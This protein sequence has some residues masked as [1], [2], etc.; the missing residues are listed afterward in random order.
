MLIVISYI[1]G[2]IEIITKNIFEENYGI[3]KIANKLH[4]KTRTFVISNM[5]PIKKG[6]IINDTTI[7]SEIKSRLLSTGLF[8][9][10]DILKEIKGDTINFKIIT[11]DVWTLGIYLN[12]EGSGSEGKIDFGIQDL[13]L[14][15]TGIWSRIFLTNS[16]EY[17]GFEGGLS[18]SSLL[19]QISFDYYSKI[20][21]LE[22]NFYFQSSR[23]TFRGIK[24]FSY[25][26]W[27]IRNSFEDKIYNVVGLN[28]GYNFKS[29][30]NEPF[31]GFRIFKNFNP[32]IGYSFSN[33]NFGFLRNV[34]NFVKEEPFSKGFSSYIA[35]G[36]N[37]ISLINS[38]SLVKE[39]ILSYMGAEFE[40]NPSYN[41]VILSNSIYYKPFHFITFAFYNGFNY[42]DIKD[43]SS[44][45]G[46]WVGGIMGIR[47]LNYFENFSNKVYRT[48]FEIRFYTNEIFNLFAFGPLFF[49]DFAYW[50]SK[51][52]VY[53]VG[54]RIQL[55]RTSMPV[56]RIDY[57]NNGVISFS[58]GQAF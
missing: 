57:A 8:Y 17:K 7:I 55:T 27:I 56:F 30:K 53:G 58:S 2:D 13:N 50:E 43:T 49:Y 29:P 16:S 12:I 46:F 34:N 1:V 44:T 32:I 39:K 47:G 51:I 6:S 21:N 15:G 48:S 37:F 40:I 23:R 26:F 24:G 38:F 33:M 18:S 14:L 42:M 45:K 22:K 41:Y 52:S 5:I 10:V 9:S 35:F 31:L 19:K 28:V 3:Y 36:Q 25:Y 20:T 54:L 4:F 11:K